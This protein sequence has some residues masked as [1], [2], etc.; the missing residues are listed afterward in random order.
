MS[1]FTDNISSFIDGAW[2]TIQVTVLSALL[3]AVVALFAGVG[4]LSTRRLVRAV[5]R[6]Y[7]EVF[8]GVSALVLM[9]WVVFSLPPLTGI[10]LTEFTGAIIALALNIGAYE[11]EIVRGGVQSVPKGQWEAATA[12]NL[13]PTKR[14]RRVI[15]PQAVAIMIPPWGTMTIHLLKASALVSLVQVVDLTYTVTQ[16]RTLD[17]GDTVPLFTG[18]LI[19]YFVLAQIIAR[20]FEWMERKATVSRA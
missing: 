13:S 1:I 6:V 7:M 5:S 9:Y 14:L 10:R 4:M 2:V 3:G 19:I 11:A 17:P 16:L 18:L 12:L 8:R 20:L 15:L